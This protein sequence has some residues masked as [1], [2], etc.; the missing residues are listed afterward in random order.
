[1]EFEKLTNV[2]EVLLFI[3]DR[4]LSLRRLK[5]VLFE[6]KVSDGEIKSA[7]DALVSKYNSPTFGIE[8][9]EVA[10]GWQF[11]SKSDYSE[12]VKKLYRERTRVKLSPSALETLSIIAYRQPITRLEVED[13]R[14]V[15]SGGVI[16]TLLER[17]LIK[18]VGRKETIGRP[19][20]YGTTQEF[21]RYFG[22]KNLSE[23]PTIEDFAPQESPAD[24]NAGEESTESSDLPSENGTSSTGENP[25]VIEKDTGESP[26]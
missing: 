17:K 5:D 9:K 19:L 8:I 18:I 15:E 26:R 12:W 14:R 24:D 22:L 21:L 6:D 25:D 11:A 10:G 13:I 4:P 3:T 23:L 20:L 16:E 7:I 2:I 1:M